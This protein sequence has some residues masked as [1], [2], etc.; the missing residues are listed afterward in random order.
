MSNPIQNRYEILF[1]FDAEN[2][3]PNGDPDAGNAPRTDPQDGRGLVSD[4]ALKRRVRDYVHAAYGD[5][6]GHG[7]FV[8]QASAL[9]RQIALAHES[10]NG[11]MPKWGS[12]KKGAPER[13][14][15]T[16]E[17]VKSASDW[18]CRTFFDVRTFGAVLSTG[19]NAGQ[20]RGAVQVAFSASVDPISTMDI[21]V[22]RVATSDDDIKGKD[23]TSQ[24]F[25]DWESA[26]PEDTLRTMGRKS[27]IPYGLF[28]AKLFVSP[29]LAE[30]TGFSE[31]DLRLLLEAL[32]NTFDHNKTSSKNLSARGL[33]VFKH[34]GTD[35]DAGQRARQARLGCAP[36]HRL[37]DVATDLMPVKE[38]LVEIR[39][40]AG[41]EYPRAFGHYEVTVH[42]DRLPKGVEMFDAL[43]GE[44]PLG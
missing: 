39:K 30:A 37:L 6:A 43:G 19:P 5:Q 31:D 17:E 3:N 29:H 23:V 7:I 26:Q 18:M 32:A 24:S 14:L 36:A 27:T 11:G 1:L 42:R 44:D 16:K 40:A 25:A 35:S 9:N 8:Q 21:A 34:V 2:C 4:V 33:Y 15:A 10:A 41:V 28:V 12:K 22:T 13:W 20:V 38:P